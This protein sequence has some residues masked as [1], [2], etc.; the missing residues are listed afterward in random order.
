[1]AVAVS[2]V[3]TT[4]VGKDSPIVIT[5]GSPY[6]VVLVLMLTMRVLTVTLNIK[7][8]LSADNMCTLCV[9]GRL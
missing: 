1:M 3:N 4:S 2:R 8:Q 9:V 6:T 7:T 5:A